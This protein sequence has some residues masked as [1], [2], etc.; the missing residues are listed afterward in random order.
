[1]RVRS[2][3]VGHLTTGN[4]AT[5]AVL[6]LGQETRLVLEPL[7]RYLLIHD[8]LRG[9]F[10]SVDIA[11]MILVRILLLQLKKHVNCRL[12]ANVETW[13]IGDEAGHDLLNLSNNLN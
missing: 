11:Q 9:V 6:G 5:L 1:M 8:R 13:I 3:G 2:Y 4:R 7:L 10:A 12:V